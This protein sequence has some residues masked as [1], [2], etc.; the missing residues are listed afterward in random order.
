MSD[1]QPTFRM[2]EACKWTHV[3]RAFHTKACGGLVILVMGKYLGLKCVC[4]RLVA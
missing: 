2:S 1:F 3:R 4:G